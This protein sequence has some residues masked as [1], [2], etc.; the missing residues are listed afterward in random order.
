MD[1]WIQRYGSCIAPEDRER[2]FDSIND[3]IRRVAPW[4]FE[5]R[6]IKPTGEEMFIRVLSQPVRLRNETVWNGIILD[7]TDRKRAEEALRRTEQ[8][9][10]RYHSFF[11]NAC[12]GVLIYEPVGQ[13]EDYIIKDVN[14]V[15][16]ALLRMDKEDLVGK[17]LFEEFPDLPS[18]YIPDLLYRV[19][20]TENPEFVTPLKYRN[21]ED[22]PWISHYVFKLPSGEIASFMI[23]VTEAVTEDA[24]SGTMGGAD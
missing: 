3:V 16:A 15:T 24:N 17:R 10:I 6:F 8:K 14:R 20:T 11:E 1:T 13:G 12:N 18:P 22:F 2:W 7:I 19:L 23:D 5:G 21:R 9:E 4:E